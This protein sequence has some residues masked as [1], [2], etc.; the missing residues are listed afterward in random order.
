VVVDQIPVAIAFGTFALILGLTLIVLTGIW[1]VVAWN[2]SARL[3]SEIVMPLEQLSRGA[4]ALTAGD[5]PLGTRS[6]PP[7]GAFAELDQL[8]E[9]FRQMNSAIQE[10]QQALEQSRDELEHR[11]TELQAAYERLKAD[12]DHLQKK[13]DELERFVKVVT[14]RELKMI[15]LKEKIRQLEQERDA[16]EEKP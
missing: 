15:E 14:N 13:I 9:D 12:E 5:F 11:N 10:R 7:P 16:H 3:H 2:L 6:L 4:S 1:F 8:T